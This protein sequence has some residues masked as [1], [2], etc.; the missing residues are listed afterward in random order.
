MDK[1]KFSLRVFTDLE[2]SS[3]VQEWFDRHCV[4]CLAKT[5]RIKCKLALIEAFTNVVRHA[6]Q[7]LPRDTPIDLEATL[8]PHQLELRIWDF[9][10]PFDFDARLQKALEANDSLS[11]G[12]RGLIIIYQGMDFVTSTRTDDGRNCLLMV[13][14]YSQ[15][16][17]EGERG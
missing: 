9:A 17:D 7:G 12:G 15:A 16:E 8:S 6:H 1:Q 2:Q 4:V 11:G 3:Q 13:K 14:H 5:D 10:P